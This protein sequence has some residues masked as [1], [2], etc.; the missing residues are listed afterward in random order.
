MS[1]FLGYPTGKYLSPVGW[2]CS[3]IWAAYLGL[4]QTLKAVGA[5]LDL[6]NQKLDEGKALIRLFSVP[7]KNGERTMPESNPEK[8]SLFKKYNKRDVEVDMDIPSLF[9]MFPVVFFFW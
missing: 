2:K 1:R 3:K 4:P 6:E 7:N 5:A 9:S 8:W